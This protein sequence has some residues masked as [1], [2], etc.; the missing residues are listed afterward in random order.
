MKEIFCP[1]PPQIVWFFSLLLGIWSRHEIAIG[2]GTLKLFLSCHA[3]T[4]SRYVLD[5]KEIFTLA[6]FELNAT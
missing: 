1:L 2:S 6:T 3:V 5:H 4:F